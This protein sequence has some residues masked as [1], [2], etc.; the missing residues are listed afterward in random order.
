MINVMKTYLMTIFLVVAVGVFMPQAQAAG[1]IKVQ[2]GTSFDVFNIGD[3]TTTFKNKIPASSFS[4]YTLK[5]DKQENWNY[6]LIDKKNDNKSLSFRIENNVIRAISFHYGSTPCSSTIYMPFDVNGKAVVIN[7]TTESAMKKLFPQNESYSYQVIG[8][9]N[10]KQGLDFNF[11]PDECNASNKEDVV[12]TI[13]IFEKGNSF[14][15]DND[16]GY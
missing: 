14:L 2:S 4:N 13:V 3:S 7:K 10:L 6:K 5:Y 12:K 15:F 1:A 16:S 11:Y 9:L 8:L